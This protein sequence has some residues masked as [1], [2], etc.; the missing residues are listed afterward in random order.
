MIRF[1]FLLA[2]AYGI[3][4][5]YNNF[6]FN[7]ETFKSDTIQAFKKEKTVKICK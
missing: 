7:L 6:N 4:W 5:G 3:Y 2:I 1:L